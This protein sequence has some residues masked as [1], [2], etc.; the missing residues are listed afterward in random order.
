M[1]LTS[2]FLLYVIYRGVKQSMSFECR[3]FLYQNLGVFYV[4]C[5][6]MKLPHVLVKFL[7]DLHYIFVDLVIGNYFKM[8]Q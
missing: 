6:L 5:M 2:C 4:L 8:F 1:V 7:V 3:D